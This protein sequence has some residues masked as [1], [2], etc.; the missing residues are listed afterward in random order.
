ML[1][2]VGFH[3]EFR[4]GRVPIASI[5]GDNVPHESAENARCGIRA[6]GRDGIGRALVV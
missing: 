3:M 4:M 6:V 2:S 1:F 5:D